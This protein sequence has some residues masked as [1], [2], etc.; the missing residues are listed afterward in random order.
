MPFIPSLLWVVIATISTIK[1][2]VA[3]YNTIYNF[4]LHCH[5]VSILYF[6]V[7][8]CVRVSL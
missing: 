4:Y 1:K 6:E 5:K 2:D 7:G 8:G 3:V